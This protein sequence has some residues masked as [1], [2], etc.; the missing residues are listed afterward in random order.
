MEVVWKGFAG[1]ADQFH[2]KCYPLIE[3]WCSSA[4]LFDNWIP[5]FNESLYAGP[6]PPSSV[7]PLAMKQ[8]TTCVN[9]SSPHAVPPFFEVQTLFVCCVCEIDKS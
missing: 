2:Q 1:T 7:F 4:G 8:H 9:L 3:G 5:G 6:H